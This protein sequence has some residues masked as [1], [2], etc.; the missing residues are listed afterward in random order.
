MRRMKTTCI[1][2]IAALAAALSLAPAAAAADGQWSVTGAG[3]GGGAVL[4]DHLELGAHSDL[5]G[6]DPRGHA[7][8]QFALGAATYNDGGHVLCVTVVGNRASVVWQLREPVSDAV[9]TYPYGAALIE[10]NGEPV[11]GQPVDRMLDFVLSPP[12]LGFFCS[13][14]PLFLLDAFDAPLTSGNFVVGDS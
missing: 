4:G 5:G 9:K 11:D 6:S 7:K 10:D 8:N 3:V 12:N 13:A 2:A 1:P 14:G